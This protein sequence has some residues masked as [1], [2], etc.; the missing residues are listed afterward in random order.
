MLDEAEILNTE[1]GQLGFQIGLLIRAA[2][3]LDRAALQELAQSQEHYDTLAP[4][5]DPTG[6]QRDHRKVARVARTAQAVEAFLKAIDAL[7]SDS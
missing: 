2:K 4:L 3:M 1:A 6:W 5:L 7:A